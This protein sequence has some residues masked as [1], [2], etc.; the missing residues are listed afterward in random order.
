MLLVNKS[1]F[2]KWNK[3]NFQRKVN[4]KLFRIIS[5]TIS[6]FSHFNAKKKSKIHSNYL[7]NK[8]ESPLNFTS[9]LTLIFL[10]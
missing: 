2:T 5:T 9:S 6:R 4:Q 7:D 10:C 1:Y 3:K 8:Q